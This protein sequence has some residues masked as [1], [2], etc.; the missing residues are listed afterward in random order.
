MLT[1][2]DTSIWIDHFKL[3][4]EK[5]IS[6]LRDDCVVI[7][8]FIL[9]EVY[10]GIYSKRKEVLTNL[11]NLTVFP[12]INHSEV[13]ML[14]DKYSLSGK[15]I[16]LVDI[17]LLLTAIQNKLNLLTYDKKLSKIYHELILH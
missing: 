11:S 14:I 13:I 7:H 3:G 12:A 4:N 9:T 17:N 1:L 6:L 10:L 5:L 15:G 8:E 16:G 2:V